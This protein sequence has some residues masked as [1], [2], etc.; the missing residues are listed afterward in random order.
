LVDQQLDAFNFE[1][2][3]DGVGDFVEAVLAGPR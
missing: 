2:L 3:A 1:D